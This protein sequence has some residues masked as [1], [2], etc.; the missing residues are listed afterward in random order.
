MKQDDVEQYEKDIAAARATWPEGPWTAEPDRIEWRCLG[1]PCLMVRSVVTGAWC[2]YVGVPPGHPYHGKGYAEVDL[3]AHGGVT[4]ADRCGGA[5]CHVPQ[6]GESD[7]V[8]W[9]GFDCAHA[10][11][12]SPMMHR[13]GMSRVVS[14]S[15][16]W[17]YRDVR[18]VKNEVERL[19]EQLAEQLAAIGS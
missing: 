9:F 4:Y 3:S 14:A 11:D 12:D 6:A 7:D 19:A 5:V 2:G 13:G 8:F 17:A 16:R 18:Y 1:L 10:W 15:A